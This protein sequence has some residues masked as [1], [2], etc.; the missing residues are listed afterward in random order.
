MYT[1][2]FSGDILVPFL[3]SIETIV[4]HHKWINRL[5]ADQ[6][7]IL[8]NKWN[9]NTFDTLELNRGLIRSKLDLKADSLA[10]HTMDKPSSIK[11]LSIETLAA[12]STTQPLVSELIR[13]PKTHL[14]SPPRVLDTRTTI[15]P[16]HVSQALN[17]VRPF[18]W[19][20]INKLLVKL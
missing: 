18:K 13:M 6:A 2:D 8:L 4:L 9:L 10:D 12:I 20:P 16:P 17:Y 3:F 15:L 19:Q 7:K 1:I 11:Q 14:V 5:M